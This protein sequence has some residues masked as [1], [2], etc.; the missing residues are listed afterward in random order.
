MIF[1]QPWQ[2]GRG[3]SIWGVFFNLS[4]KSGVF[5]FKTRPDFGWIASAEGPLSEKSGPE[6]SKFYRANSPTPSR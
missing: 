5:Q 3:G 1:I 6:T 4:K 2:V